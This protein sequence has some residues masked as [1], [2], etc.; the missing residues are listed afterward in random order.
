MASMVRRNDVL[1]HSLD[2]LTES[3]APVVAGD[4]Y[5][6]VDE[7][8]HFNSQEREIL[9]SGQERAYAF[10]MFGSA[11]L[12]TIGWIDKTPTGWVITERGRQEFAI[13]ARTDVFTRASRGYRD[14]KRSEVPASDDPR[15][16]LLSEALDLIEPG[17][18][19]SY[20]DLA[21]LTN[22]ANQQVGAWAMA[23]DHAAA[24]RVLG[25]DGRVASAFKWKDPER[26]DTP[27]EV[28]T[29]E[30]IDFDESDRASQAQRVTVEALRELLTT[31]EEAPQRAWFVR[32]NAVDGQNLVRTWLAKGTCSLR[33]NRLR[34]LTPPVDR[35][36]LAAYVEE[37]YADRSYNA[38]SEKLHEFDLFLNR[39]NVGDLVVTN[40]GGLYVGTVTG[41]AES[42]VSADGR[43]NL[44]RTVTW[45][46]AGSP[47]DLETTSKSFVAL[48]R[49]QRDIFDVSSELAMLARVVEPGAPEPVDGEVHRLGEPTPELAGDLLID[50]AWLER[51]VRLLRDRRQLIL[52]GPPGTGKTFLAKTLAQSLTDDKA[53]KLVQFHPSYSYE[54]FF[55]GFRPTT[56]TDGAMSFA[57]RPGPFR[58]LVDLARDDKSTAYILIID[59]INRAN[60]AK[61]FGELYFLLEYRDDNIDLLYGSG[62]DTGGGFTLP[63]NVYIIGTMNTADRSIA[64][65]DAAMRRRFA[66]LAMHPDEEPTKGLL[67]RWLAREELDSEVADLHD[68]LNERIDDAD[69]KIGPSYFMRSSVYEPDGLEL[70]WSTAILPLLEEHHFGEGLEVTRRYGLDA[71]RRVLSSRRETVGPVA[72]IEDTDES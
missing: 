44:R 24:F 4:V 20:S 48:A 28:L 22:M 38:R 26:T 2:L 34:T 51:M 72:V 36:T 49:N 58:R 60:L 42:L 59:E 46:N 18:W 52:Y 68:L 62:D 17:L 70:T 57:L 65:V 16:R 53:V 35:P 37:D 45:H 31:D 32:G 64:L 1:C 55:E 40:D 21:G 7:R 30:G 27:Q 5:R 71:L 33:A 11:W 10:L 29:A 14:I 50:L 6:A 15:H 12:K 69:F 3:D 54:D 41:D 66:F 61:V 47:V 56:S 67:R 43:S 19:T 8:L 39:V 25:V 23:S 13:T 9:P 63:E